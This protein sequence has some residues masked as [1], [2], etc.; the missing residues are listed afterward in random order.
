M[1][2]ENVEVVRRF[3]EAFNQGGVEAVISGG[4]WS[5]EVVWDPSPSGVPGIGIYR[6]YDEIRA[7]FEEDWFRTFPFEEWEIVVE[8]LI[9]HGEDQ[10]IAMS[11][12]R[13]RGASSGVA[14][15]LEQA[16]ICTLRDGEIVR[17]E[18]YLDRAKALE[19]AGLRE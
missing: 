4:F 9:D 6:G 15:E 2:Q 16:H 19:A 14:A 8:E 17:A 7:F 10:V 13:G 18:S 5:P 1:S 12:Q 11:H 3:F